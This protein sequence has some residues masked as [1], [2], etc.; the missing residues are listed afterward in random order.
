MDR[1]LISIFVDDI[2]IMGLE[3]SG[4]TKRVKMKLAAAFS[5]LDIGLRV[6]ISKSLSSA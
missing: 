3:E 5:V 2:K 4:M 6:F 1:P